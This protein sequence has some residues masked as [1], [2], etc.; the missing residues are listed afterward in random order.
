M[1]DIDVVDSTWVNA[2]PATV[3][4]AVSEP[5][6]WRRWWPDL[7]LEV[8]EW[9]GTKGVRWT[10]RSAADHA[11]GTMEIW[12]EPSCDGVVLHYFLR[13]DAEAGHRLGR[14]R[15][16]RIVDARRRGCKQLF[17]GLADQLDVRRPAR[18][19]TP[20]APEPAAPSR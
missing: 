3:A 4:A 14:R 16:R 2:P 19:A 18:A 1:P 10:A 12:L 8:N 17:W 9:R 11:A 6:N 13:L 5:A 15:C 7:T 20:V